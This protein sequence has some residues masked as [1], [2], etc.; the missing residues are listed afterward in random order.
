MVNTGKRP[1]EKRK[2]TGTV[3]SISTQSYKQL[4]AYF[5]LSFGWSQAKDLS[6]FGSFAS[7]STFNANKAYKEHTH[8]WQPGKYDHAKD[9]HKHTCCTS[10]T[11]CWNNSLEEDSNS[12]IE[13]S[14]WGRTYR[15][16]E[17]ISDIP[18]KQNLPDVRYFSINKSN[19]AWVQ[20]VPGVRYFQQDHTPTI[21][22]MYETYKS[23]PYSIKHPSKKYRM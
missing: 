2:K 4:W 22:H 13:R 12:Q 15:H 17:K 9:I 3:R 23:I 14:C 21:Q 11:L 16:F 7:K 5:F 10:L 20:K 18:T 19:Q 1:A 8:T 6:T